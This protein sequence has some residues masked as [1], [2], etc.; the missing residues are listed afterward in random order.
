MAHELGQGW[1]LTSG[2]VMITRI[3]GSRVSVAPCVVGTQSVRVDTKSTALVARM[4][5]L[6]AHVLSCF[7]RVALKMGSSGK[8]A[9]LIKTI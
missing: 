9:T 1:F 7:A 4:G 8:V 3:A 6:V 5:W 2:A